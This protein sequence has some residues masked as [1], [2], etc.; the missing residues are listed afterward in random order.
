VIRLFV[1]IE[2]PEDVRQRLAGLCV[3]V[4]GARWV[5]PENIHLT[6]RF[7]GEVPED[8]CHDIDAAL[9][10]IRAP[11]FDVALEG[12]GCFPVRGQARV[13][14]AGV[15]RNDA[16]AHLYG[17]VESALVRTG[18]EPEGRKFSPHVT[19][20]R[21]RGAPMNRV[22]GFIAQNHLFRAGPF[23]VETFTLFSSFLSQS[24]AIHRPE[25]SYPLSAAETG[26]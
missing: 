17:K 2:L 24:G 10:Q 21:L 4:P 22:Q 23:A 12:V 6:L 1:A 16:V 9:S 3:G 8:R 13:L 7:I 5:R 20:A 25:A 14:W 26:P 18:L 11:G 15:S 19:L